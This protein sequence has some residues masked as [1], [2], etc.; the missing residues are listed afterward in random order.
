MIVVAIR[1]FFFVGVIFWYSASIWNVINDYFRNEFKSY[2]DQEQKTAETTGHIQ[3]K[4]L[5]KINQAIVAEEIIFGCEKFSSSNDF[6]CSVPS[7]EF[8]VEQSCVSEN[9]WTDY[10]NQNP[11]TL[12]SFTEAPE[13]DIESCSATRVL[14]DDFD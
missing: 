12:N 7:E 6:K 10:W 8:S 11:K 4:I 5:E 14:K 9:W 2:L 3:G 13:K 1:S